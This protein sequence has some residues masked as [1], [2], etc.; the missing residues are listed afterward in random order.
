MTPQAT[1]DLYRATRL[2]YSLL[3]RAMLA[4]W[5]RLTPSSDWDELWPV[6]GPRLTALVSSAQLGAAMDGAA[7]VGLTFA[8]LGISETPMAAVSP[9]A[10]AGV[11]SDGRPL[12]TLMRQSLTV[13]RSTP[14]TADEMLSAGRNW[15]AVAAQV[16]V[17]DAAR[18]ATAT[19]IVTTPNAGWVRHVNPPCCPDCALQAGKWF[20]WNQGF[21]RH[22]GCDC[23]HRPAH[24]SEDP[25]GYV[26][27]VPL[28]Q[29]H[30]LTDAQRMALEDGA[31]LGQ[32][33]NAYRKAQRDKA[34]RLVEGARERMGFTTEGTTRR[35]W[36]SYVARESGASRTPRPTPELIYRNAR[37]R[38]EAV[39]LLRRFGYVTDASVPIAAR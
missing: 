28:D 6:V 25:A 32:V 15:L 12:D 39:D 31:D 17:A 27:E 35:G 37:S 34:G 4:E 18:Q 5:A 20:R 38:E 8:Q 11:A 30:G 10:F 36:A 1:L 21:E 13:A 19:A 7:S 23:V 24:S 2:R 33:V 14:G 26:Y 29:I 9:A 22:P 3:L 16:Q